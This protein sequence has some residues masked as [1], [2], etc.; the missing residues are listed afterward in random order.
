MRDKWPTENT[1]SLLDPL[2]TDE[3]PTPLSARDTAW[4]VAACA[5]AV[6]IIWADLYGAP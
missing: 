3:K 5:A 2:L 1:L 4:I 6:S